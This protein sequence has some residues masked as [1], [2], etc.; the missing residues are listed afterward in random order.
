MRE[1]SPHKRLVLFL[2]LFFLGYFGVHRF[3]VGKI[4]TGLLFVLTVGGL[5]LWWLIDLILILVGGFTD[6]EGRLVVDWT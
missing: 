5:G 3:V 4:G 2:L 6:K 1:V